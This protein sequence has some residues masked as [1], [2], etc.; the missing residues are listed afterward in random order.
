MFIFGILLLSLC[1]A[2]FITG[3]VFA[4][5]AKAQKK[6]S[7]K[8]NGTIVDKTIHNT[9][10]EKGTVKIS[11]AGKPEVYVRTGGKTSYGAHSYYLIY[12]YTVDGTSYRNTT[13]YAVGGFQAN[14]KIGKTVTVNYNL[15]HPEQSS[16][17][18]KGIYKKLGAFLMILGAFG[19]IVGLILITLG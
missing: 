3:I 15:D 2:A 4:I 6:F 18:G 12:E 9:D 8:A 11:K 5:V 17:A 14:K 13:G 10:F 19:C 7:A 16:I 1:G